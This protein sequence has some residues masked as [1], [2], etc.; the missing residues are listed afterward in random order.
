MLAG[1]LGHNTLESPTNQERLV[2][3]ADDAVEPVVSVVILLA[4]AVFV[5]RSDPPRAVVALVPGARTSS[6][7]IGHRFGHVGNDQARIDAARQ[8]GAQRDFALETIGDGLAQQVGD[9]GLH[10]FR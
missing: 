3:G 1:D 6:H 9:L 8:E 4:C 7:R 5:R 2:E 10:R